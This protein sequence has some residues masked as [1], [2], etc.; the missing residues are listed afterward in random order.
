MKRFAKA[1]IFFVIVH[2]LE[3]QEYKICFVFLAEEKRRNRATLKG[4]CSLFL[5]FTQYIDI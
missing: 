1:C 4:L 5:C 3:I 2:S